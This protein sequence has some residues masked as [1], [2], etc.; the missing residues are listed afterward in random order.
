[1]CH[2]LEPHGV[3]YSCPCLS[4]CTHTAFVL[5][6]RASAEIRVIRRD[7]ANA[8]PRSSPDTRPRRLLRRRH[9]HLP[10]VHLRAE[11]AA[12]QTSLLLLRP[13]GARLLRFLL[14]FPWLPR[15][16]FASSTT[17]G[18]RVTGLTTTQKWLG[19]VPCLSVTAP[20]SILCAVSARLTC[21]MACARFACAM[22]VRF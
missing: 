20:G 6:V 1:M 15:R 22:P 9:R 12:G 8:T 11:L 16:W 4:C 21:V 18:S 2:G 17:S 10:L 13:Q 3:C 5:A 14:R 19:C 7:T